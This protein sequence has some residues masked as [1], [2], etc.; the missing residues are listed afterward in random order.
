MAY[1][2]YRPESEQRP[3][4]LRPQH[5]SAAVYFSAN[6]NLMNRDA[7]RRTSH[8]SILS[9]LTPGLPRT[10]SI[11]SLVETPRFSPYTTPIFCLRGI[12]VSES[13]GKRFQALL[14]NTGYGYI[15][16]ATTPPTACFHKKGAA[17]GGRAAPSRRQFPHNPGGRWLRGDRFLLSFGF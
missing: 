4:N 2:S 8:I 1:L 3:P 9:K 7:A 13:D 11:I 17:R 10:S 14:D 15:T 12:Q 6:H 16:E 5:L